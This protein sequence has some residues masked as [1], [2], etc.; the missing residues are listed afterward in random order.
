MLPKVRSVCENEKGTVLIGTRG[1][2]I[3][4]IDINNKPKYCLRSHHEG[5]LWGL[6]THPNKEEF[7]TVG[8]D[9]ILAIWDIKQ[10]RQKQYVKLDQIANVASFSNNGKVLALGFINGL[11]MFLDAENNL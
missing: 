4:E 6:T 5:E 8:Q 9:N 1:G 3:I 7:V 10:K 11:V 2:E